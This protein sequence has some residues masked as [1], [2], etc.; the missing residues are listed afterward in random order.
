M[1]TKY[2]IKL[3]LSAD[4]WIYVTEDKEAPMFHIHPMLFDS[5]QAAEKHAE[6]WNKRFTK[7]VRWREK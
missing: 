5:R 2:A 6:I 4:D 7:V 1:K 3:M